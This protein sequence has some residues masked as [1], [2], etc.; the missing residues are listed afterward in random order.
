[1]DY[2]SEIEKYKKLLDAGALSEEEFESQRSR[3]E[4]EKRAEELKSQQKAKNKKKI[5]IILAAVIGCIVLLVIV[6]KVIIPT[7]KYNK[8]LSLIDEGKYTES[9][10]M[11]KDLNGFKDSKQKMK[12]I[13]PEVNM[14]KIQSAGVGSYVTLGSYPQ[15]SSDYDEDIEWLVLDKK[16]GKLLLI[17]RYVLDARPYNNPYESKKTNDDWESSWIRGWL[18]DDF[19]NKA[20]DSFE[21]SHIEHSVV[22]GRETTKKTEAETFDKIFLL[23]WDELETYFSSAEA[24]D[25]EPTEYA[26]LEDVPVNKSWG[27][28]CFWLTR[29]H[30]TVWPGGGLDAGFGDDFR[31][32]IRPA[33]WL[34]PLDTQDAEEPELAPEQ[35]Y[36]SE[37]DDKDVGAGSDEK[38]SNSASGNNILEH[39]DLDN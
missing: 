1:M 4:S 32:G 28:G 21:Q 22:K 35:I 29:G 23:S 38:G 5:G 2:N 24:R 19:L 20:F 6:S 12:Q 33:L 31:A 7:T 17:S 34:D 39:L 15:S 18:N 11:L 25:A 8:A 36:S 10:N 26:L 9:Y 37:D 14:E 3:L 27:T 16:D 30:N 13:W